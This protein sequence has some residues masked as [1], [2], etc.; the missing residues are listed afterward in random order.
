VGW[1]RDAGRLLASDEVG[2]SRGCPSECNPQQSEIT[3]VRVSS[4]DYDRM[5]VRL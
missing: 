2:E 1:A 5:H 3:A 4:L